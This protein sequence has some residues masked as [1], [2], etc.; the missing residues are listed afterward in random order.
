[1]KLNTNISNLC[2]SLSLSIIFISGCSMV[3]KLTIR[4]YEDGH[5][6]NGRYEANSNAANSEA[7]IFN[8]DGTYKY[9]GNQV[10][11]NGTYHISGPVI[12]F[13]S[14]G[15]KRELAITCLVNEI[16][17]ETPSHILLNKQYY[18]RK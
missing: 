13:T 11:E 1:M 4:G 9:S 2:L 15:N 6:L 5:K 17:S 18:Y 3:N 12:T 16:S 10:A 8:P 7:Y 14:G